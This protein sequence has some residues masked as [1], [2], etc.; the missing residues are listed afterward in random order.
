MLAQLVPADCPLGLASTHRPPRSVARG[1]E[2]HGHTA[3]GPEKYPGTRA[4]AAWNQNRL[5]DR[6]ILLRKP[7]K[8][9]AEGACRALAVHADGHLLPVQRVLLDLPHI[10]GN[11]VDLVKIPAFETSCESLFERPP[12]VV[13]QDLSVAERVVRRASHRRQIAFAFR[14][15]ERRTY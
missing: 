1:A 6:Q 9:R 13:G 2:G 11:V 8:A 12:S 15:V 14:G 3:L 5:P 7:G 10:V 4:H